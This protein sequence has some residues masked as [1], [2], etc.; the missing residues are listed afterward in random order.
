MI[1]YRNIDNEIITEKCILE[2]CIKDDLFGL[3]QSWV[4]ITDALPITG[5]VTIGNNGNWFVDGEDTGFKA[6]G[7]KGDNGLPLQPRLSEDK[8]KIEFSYNGIDWHELF[9][10]SLITPTIDFVE[11]IAL[12]PGATPTVEN[13][14][15][16]FNAI[17][18]VGLPKAPEVN[19]GS[20]TTIGEGNKAKV[21]NSGTKYAPILNFEFP[22]GD[23]GNGLKILGFYDTF[24]NLNSKVTAPEISDTYCVGT[25]EP[26]HL[27]VWTNIYNPETQESA[28]GWKDT[29]TMNK[30]TTIIVNDLGD[31]EDV[32]VSQKGMTKQLSEYI[33]IIA[34][35][36]IPNIIKSG[37]VENTTYTVSFNPATY[38][39]INKNTGKLIAIDLSSKSLEELTFTINAG[40]ALIFDI[41]TKELKVVVH[42]D[43]TYGN[44]IVL[45]NNM[46]YLSGE[47]S[48]ILLN[49]VFSDVESLKNDKGKYYIMVFT[50]KTFPNIQYN[51]EDYTYTII[52]SESIFYLKSAISNT[53]IPDTQFQGKSI[54]D[55][56]F[57]VNSGE[58]FYYDIPTKKFKVENI[59]TA[60]FNFTD[61]ILLLSNSRFAEA[62]QLINVL[63]FETYID[64][65]NGV[66]NYYDYRNNCSIISNV[67]KGNINKLYPIRK[68][69]LYVDDK[70]INNQF[71][72][73]VL[74][75]NDR[76]DKKARFYIYDVTNA[77]NICLIDIEI[78]DDIDRLKTI[79]HLYGNYTVSGR[80]NCYLDAV[81]DWSK[82]KEKISTTSPTIFI[83]P[84]STSSLEF[85]SKFNVSSANRISAKSE[86]FFTVEVNGEKQNSENGFLGIDSDVISSNQQYNDMCHFVFPE[87]D[88]KPVKLIILC[89][90][91][92]VTVTENTDN[93]Y[94]YQNIGKIFNALGYA[95]L[96]TNGMPRDWANEN[97]IGIDRQCGNWMAVQ[98]VVKAYNYVISK[99][100][101]DVNGCYVYGQSQG[102]M[103]AEN[104]AELSGLPI[105][106]TVLES[107]AISMQYAQ[108]YIPSALSYL[109]ALYGF[110]SQETYNK[111][112]CIGLDP[113]IRN[114]EP[115]ITMTGNSVLTLDID[116]ETMEQKKYRV[117]TPILIIRS[118]NDATISPKVIGAYAKA[119]MNAGGNCNLITYNNAGHSP[120]ASTNIIG[121]LEGYDVRSALYEIASFLESN[122]G[123]KNS[124]NT[125]KN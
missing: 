113:F 87:N 59:N 74:E 30:D 73:G 2:D 34:L 118:L 48:S 62:G 116:I 46:R 16:D 43:F 82:F 40:N 23:T 91:G 114:V 44:K 24:E 37:I 108:L 120:I 1:S 76:K 52:F 84:K 71:G 56:T 97:G 63:S 115:D 26:Y 36:N 105:L 7:P 39:I 90:G 35:G 14:G 12:E 33:F 100:N 79:S 11:P 58:V 13:V 96:L 29:G 107:P 51:Q 32:V 94:N 93:W 110:N 86:E 103:V 66:D 57:I 61:N 55:R 123:Y 99:Y 28:P 15:D 20:T 47:F 106:A 81:I 54:E 5:N 122:G 104:I 85:K 77:Y 70:D 68:L 98:S 102:G 69:S 75:N 125:N 21:T 121:E 95:V 50:Q 124:I 8:T 53:T 6:Q 60:T 4:R 49:T 64:S 109:Q 65:L 19:I 88:G 10:L 117:N 92:G 9:P 83:Q 18:Q 31:R 112:K 78:P 25:A 89:H 17:L 80:I 22:K 111:N 101:V 42:T 72:I 27:Y 3:D 41:D 119:I 38:Y 45:L 67:D